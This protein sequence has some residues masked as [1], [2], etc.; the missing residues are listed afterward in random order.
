M[1]TTA[2]TGTTAWRDADLEAYT[3]GYVEINGL[4]LHYTEWNPAGR[5]HLVMLHG[6]NVQAHTWDPLAAALAR[7]HHV[8]CPDLRGHGE[9]DWASDGYRLRG[10]VDDLLAL[11]GRLGLPRFDLVGHS[12]GCRIATV[13]AAEHPDLVERLVLSDAAP[14]LP[15]EALE[16]TAKVVGTAGGGVRGFRDE[17]EAAE[18]YRSMH[19]EWQPVFIDLHVRHQLRRNW[20][21]RLIFRADPDLFWLL[22]SAGRDDDPLVWE[23]TGRLTMP[24]LIMWGERSPFLDDAI[25]ARMLSLMSDGRLARTDSGHYIPRE[26]PAEFLAVA[27]EFLGSGAA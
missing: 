18:Y 16:F 2:Q 25:A 17:A 5:R 26:A 14:E 1:S 8:I 3:D 15:R 11:T 13:L 19:P 6:L 23:M 20:A 10:F 9:S 21:G 12:L 27:G 24:T 4:R 7:D 22:G